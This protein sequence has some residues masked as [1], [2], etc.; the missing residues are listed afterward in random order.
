VKKLLQFS[1]FLLALIFVAAQGFAQPVVTYA[2]NAGTNTYSFPTGTAIATQT[3][4]VTG[5]PVG[6]FANF[7]NWAVPK[8]GNSGG[9]VYDATIAALY[10]AEYNYGELDQ[11]SLAAAVTKLDGNLTA[12][13]GYCIVTDASGTVYYNYGTSVYVWATGTYTVGA[14]TKITGF[15]AIKGIAVDASNNFYVVDA[16][17]GVNGNGK[18]YK[19]AT[20]A[21][22]IGAATSTLTGLNNPSGIAISGNNIFLAEY[23]TTIATQGIFEITNGVTTLAAP[24]GFVAETTVSSVPFKAP[25]NLTFDANGNL[26]VADQGNAKIERISPTGTLAYLTTLTNVTSPEQI[27]FDPTG[28]MYCGDLSGYFKRSLPVYYS[29]TGTIPPGLTFNNY[30]GAITGTPT[31]SG[32]YSIVVTAAST[33]GN[34]S[35]LTTVAFTI[36]TPLPALSYPSSPYVYATGAAVSITP[37][38]TGG[39]PTS[40]VIST[41][42]PAG[43]SISATGV[44]TGSTTVASSVTYTVTPSNGTGAGAASNNFTITIEPAPIFTFATPFKAVNAVNFSV[45]PTVTA[46]APITSYAITT[47]GANLITGLTFNTTTGAFGGPTTGAFAAR[48]FTVTATNSYGLTSTATFSVLSTAVVRFSYTSPPAY[49]AGTAITALSPASTYTISQATI[50]PDLPTGLTMSAAGVITGTPTVASPS[51]AYQVIAYDGTYYGSAYVTISVVAPA[52]PVPSYTPPSYSFTVGTAGTTSAITNTGGTATYSVDASTP[53][54]AYLTLN[55]TTGVITCA[56]GSTATAAAV[57]KIDATNIT[58][59]VSTTVTITVVNPTPP[60]IAYS[61]SSYTFVAGT[62]GVTS[63][64]TNT[65]GTGVTYTAD[66][67]TPF[68][69]YLTI[70]AATGVI[71]CS[72]AATVTAATGYQVDATN[73]SGSVN[74]TVTITIN[75]ALP[76]IAYSPATYTFTTGV[77]G[78][79]SAPN[80]TGG[81]V[82]TYSAD[83]STPFPAYLS[84]NSATGV[85]TASA[86]S[87]ATAATT[88]KIDATNIT[89]TGTTTIAITILTPPTIAYTGSP[90]VY[91]VGTA[92]TSLTPATT[93][94]PTSFAI[95]PNLTT[96]TGLAFSTTTGVISGTPTTVSAAIV[97]TVTATNAG[98]SG[99]T[100]ISIQVYPKAPTIAYTG[101]P[102]TY[103]NGAAITTLTPAVTG[104]PTSYTISPNLTTN[105]GLTFN[106]G[107]GQISG[108]PTT[109]SAAVIYTISAYNANPTPGTT[110]ISIAVLNPPT[111]AYTGSPFVYTVGTA[112]TSLTPA[113]TNSPTSYSISPNLTTN[114][115]L[116]FSTTTGIISG[117]PTT[118]SAAVVYTVTATNAAGPG[119][120]MISIQVYPK[121]PTIAYTGSPFTYGNGVAITTLTPTVTGAPTSYT[122]SPNLNTN[123]GLTFNTGTGQISG[124][125][126][127][128]SAAVTYTISAYNANPTPG[129]TTISITVVNPPIIVYSPPG[130]TFASGTAGA[131]AAPTNTGGAVVTYSVDASTPFPSYL[132]ISATTGIITCSTA[133]TITAATVYQIDATN[134][135]GT[136]SANITITINPPLPVIDYTPASYTF[137]TGVATSTSAPNS[138]GGAVVTYAVDASTPFPAYLSINSSTG[139][140]TSSASSVVTAATTYKID[141]TNVSGTSTTPITITVANPPTVAYTGSPFNYS[142][143]TAITTLT[144]T[145]TGSPTSFAVSPNL[146]TNTGLSFS[147]T[148]GV[149]SGTPTTASAATTYT[150]TATSARGTGTTTISIQV[151][152]AGPTIAYTGS[153]YSFGV[154]TAITPETPTLTG[155]PTV[156]TISPNLTTNTGLAF[157]TSTGVISGTPT[158]VSAATTYT[159]TA[160]N[161]NPTLGSTTIS[162]ATAS[163]SGLTYTTPNNYTST[164][165]ITPLSPTNTGAP[166]VSLTYGAGVPFTGGTLAQP[167]GLAFDAAGNVYAANSAAATNNVVKYTNGVYQAIAVARTNF[168]SKTDPTAVAFD[169]T[170]DIYVAEASGKLYEFTAAGAYTATVTTIATAIDGMWIDASNNIYLADPTDKAV[171]KYSTSGTLLMTISLS[172]TGGTPYGVAVDNTGNIYILDQANKEVLKYSSTGTLI[173][174]G[175]SGLTTPYGLYVDNAGNIYVTDPGS[176]SV[177]VTNSSGTV[178]AII[179]GLTNPRGVVVDGSGNI[180]VSDYTNNTITEYPPLGGYHLNGTLPPGFSFD[181]TT[182][183]ITG[184]PTTAFSGTYTVTGYSASG[185]EVS[186]TFVITCTLPPTITYPGSSF[187]YIVGTA[188]TTLPPTT[189]NSP[190]SFSISPN[191]G[192]NTGLTFNTTTGIISG[193]PTLGSA[194]ITYTVTATNAAGSGTTSI[195]ITVIAKPNFSYTPATFYVTGA[196]MSLSPVNAPTGGAVAPVGYGAAIALTTGGNI[197]EPWGMVFDASGNLYE[198]NYQNGTVYKYTGGTGTP[199]VFITGL[200]QPTGIV[201]DA[202][203]NVYVSQLSGSVYKYSS[204]GTGKT[205]IVTGDNPAAG[206]ATE[207]GS[208]Y[209]LAIDGSGNLYMA[210][211]NDG[212]IYK[213]TAST[214][215]TSV[216]IA[217]GSPV[218]A[219]PDGLAVDAAGDIYFTDADYGVLVKYTAAGVY[220]GTV[221]GGMDEPFGLYLDRSGNFY[222]PDVGTGDVYVYNSAGELLNMFTGFTAPQGVV[223]DSSGDIFISDFSKNT[224]TEYPITGGY[225]LN[226][227]TGTSGLPP[228]VSFNTSTGT[229]SGTPT[230]AFSGNYTV[231]GINLAGNFTCTQFNINIIT[232]PSITYTGSPYVYTIG[233]PITTLTPVVTGSPTSIYITPNLTANTGLS[234]NPANGVISGTPTILSGAISYTVTV[235]NAADTSTTTISFA[236]VQPPSISYTPST[237]NY[238]VGTAIPPL[239]PTSTGVATQAF[240]SGSA[241]TGGTLDGPDA[242]AIDASG[243]VWVTNYYSGTVVEYSSSGTYVRTITLPGGTNS[244]PTGVVTDASGNVY[245]LGQTTGDVYEYSSTGTLLATLTVN[246]DLTGNG[247]S[248]AIDRNG[249]LYAVNYNTNTL[250]EFTTSGIILMTTTTDLNGPVS[251]AVDNSGNIWVL[252]DGNNTAVELSSNGAYESE[253]TSLNTPHTITIDASGNL[254]VSEFGTGSVVEYQSNGVQLASITGLDDPYGMAIDKSGDLYV[255]DFETMTLMKYPPVGGYYISGP[256]PPGL[257]FSTTTGTF[258]GTPTISWPLTTYTVTTYDAAGTAIT[259]TVS[260]QCTVTPVVFSYTTPDV[261]PVNAAIAPLAPTITSG[262]VSGVSFGSGVALTGGTLNEPYGVTIDPANGDIYVANYGGNS[263]TQYSAAGTFIANITTNIPNAPTAIVFDS[264]GD[265]FIQAGGTVYKYTGGLGGTR[266]SFLTGLNNTANIP[267][268][269]AMDSNNNIYIV[270]SR[271]TANS[272]VREYATGTGT[273][274]TALLTITSNLDNPS[275]IAVDASGNIYVSNYTG[276]TVYEYSATNTTGTRV[277]TGTT[278]SDPFGIAVDQNNNLYVANY[279]SSVI[280][281]VNPATSL[282]TLVTSFTSST[283]SGIV[284]N[285]QG[286]AFVINYSDNSL[287][288]YPVTSGFTVAGTL[289]PGLTFNSTTGTFTGTPT[290]V[291]PATTYTVTAHSYGVSSTTTVTIQVILSFDW[292]GTTSTDWNTKTN[293]LSQTVPGATNTANIGVNYAFTNQPNVGSTGANA[294]SAVQIGNTGGKAVT[295]TVTSPYTLAVTNAITLQSDA[296]AS[297]GYTTATLTGTGIITAANLA[298]TANTTQATPASYTETIASSVTSLQLSGNIALTSSVDGS[299]NALNAQFNLTGGVTTL[300]T[301][302]LLTTANGATST[303]TFNLS[304]GTL[305]VAAPTFLA[306]LSASGT[307]AVTLGTGSVVQYSGAAQTVYTTSAITNLSGGTGL[308]YG[309][310]AFSGTG[311]KSPTAG[312][313]LNVS[314]NF[315]NTMANDAADYVALTSTPV[316]FNGSTAQS[317][318]G[319]S[320]NGTVFKN[321][322]FDGGSTATMASGLF[323]VSNAGVLTMV[324]GASTGTSLNSGGFLTLNADVTGCAGVAQIPAG[325]SITGTVNVQR[326]ISGE[327]GYRLLSSPV[328]AGSQNGN[329]IYSINYLYNSLYLTGSGS[330]FTANGNPTLYLYDES[331]VP[332]YSTFYNSNFI[333]ISSLSSGTGTDPAYPVNVNGANLTG[334]YNIPAGNGYYCFYRGNLSEGAANLTNPS[335]TPIVPTTITAAGTL[336]QGQIT[337]A[338]WYSPTSTNLGSV[339]QNYNLIGN[340]YACAIDLAS[341]QGTLTNS[342]IYLTPY[343]GTTGIAKFIYE[344]NPVSG[345]YG[346]YTYDGTAPSTN[347]AIEFIA[348][349][350]GFMVQAYGPTSTLIFNENAKATA[351]NATSYGEMARRVSNFNPVKINPL[352]EL[353]MSADSIHTEETILSFDP[354]SSSKYVFNE[355]APHRAGVGIV[356]ISSMS[357]DNM[358]MAINTQPLQANMTIPLNVN[359]TVSGLYNINMNQL[360]PLP[361]I[362]EVWLKDAYKKDSLDIKDNPVYNFDINISDTTT[363]GSNRFS[364][365]IR[366]N[367]ALMVHLLSFDATKAVAGVKVVWTT[368]NEQNYT[369]FT[370]ERSTDGGTTFANLGALT[371]TAIGAYNYLDRNPV[372]GANMY[373][374]MIVDLNGAISYSN[375]VTIMYSNTGNQIALN[376]GM[377]VYPNPTAGMVNLTIEQTTSTTPAASLASA[378]YKIEIVNNLGVVVRNAT[379]STP[380]WTSDVTSLSPGTYFISVVNAS[381][382]SVVGKSAFVKL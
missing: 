208:A 335:Y 241:L 188:I 365:V 338:N 121:V 227:G 179:A 185:K 295:L 215:A 212:S 230:V 328:Y 228:G 205:Q 144:P 349:G 298:A 146:T 140:I 96:N 168:P 220:S 318:A 139:V 284:I 95:S 65:G 16:G 45:L 115:G 274:G 285:S 94:A 33:S 20:G 60:A 317:L 289:P 35:P 150:I 235:S 114:T 93:N 381:N 370:V 297:L 299:G 322:T 238:T 142:A 330:G 376:G 53:F 109:A 86:A 26:Y 24:T 173:G 269:L 288:E 300:T 366:E 345:S 210:D 310:I 195:V 260:I 112:I 287:I 192:N 224:I 324:N 159:V 232:G 152:P 77:A 311:I 136:G 128:A 377:M 44:I 176:G 255:S 157:S 293:W 149:I 88:Y 268:G 302:G 167:W 82:V 348:S 261:Y 54:P 266:T 352:L 67:S 79:T 279:G 80:S 286:D 218:I 343:N 161:G 7:T 163:L 374:L 78:S 307:N 189:T 207:P 119:T 30:T 172:A 58:A 251:V 103:Y 158:S 371:S 303:S 12:N 213:Y 68:P 221:G 98:G 148:T 22:T 15:T 125:P 190:T 305:Q 131:I 113:T 183:I 277:L 71:T 6:T 331:F 257:S 171:Y 265:A 231:T 347:G 355:D 339:S 226:Y 351:P 225:T 199:T 378:S 2:G 76:I 43:L 198:V 329:Y 203:G 164:A 354:K 117:T 3:P 341:V 175:G 36:T 141:A 63:A 143:G 51:T 357:S 242:V 130:Y 138:T 18:I 308:S 248:L 275:G 85:I 62:G 372:I 31:S 217:K 211:G 323:Y 320:G 56:A 278:L 155:N 123:T 186:N 70:N 177:Y 52:A 245:V 312:G 368:E 270:S 160:S 234:F 306:N 263:I 296:N 127:M 122:I 373:R 202:A 106:T 50:S 118:A 256:I 133:A 340:P 116:A 8:N 27:A 145:T 222:V 301:A 37:T 4:T 174:T 236:V 124:T 239:A 9:M 41:P 240:G 23:G 280:D 99:T 360:A 326:Y 47:G 74:A 206:T 110:T 276:N 375:I 46:G 252:N 21:T 165:A 200:N 156:F 25:A 246:G 337:F 315:T 83:A 201:I 105:T 153:P 73:V 120:T 362:Y 281:V 364:L 229:F 219:Y 104:A 10:G 247:L 75:P 309:G 17:N 134:A 102:F 344:L 304:S 48:L 271:N 346:I 291:W 332:Q 162:I 108:T 129:T 34:N 184:T 272:S 356:G 267:I 333:A 214:G 107:T 363:Y 204:T 1:F 358:K 169:N 61:P 244:S 379:S 292:I 66:A 59:T 196:A 101:S 361:S 327:R 84:I 194:S 380:T 258:T 193:T 254:Y 336:I 342:G 87:V 191:L 350:E 313:N 166:V 14:A 19:F 181:S 250:Y 178:L 316:F 367:P 314:G 135:G 359:A 216:V 57:Y 100:M 92:I 369:N 170:G 39:T 334:S 282:T 38:S 13:T 321:V 29:Y 325:C 187:T 253:L 154:G 180:Y 382:N 69:A 89:G 97:Y 151:Y 11:I 294:V 182:G 111:I 233:T 81:A 147:T 28:N 209:A 55:T 126:T 237:N 42:L 353:K 91:T 5:T 90:F 259:T 49:T 290:A 243:N 72:A 32:S 319:G 283:P 273:A 264:S 197:K 249:N 64:A 223:T 132:T 137:T 262:M 40:V